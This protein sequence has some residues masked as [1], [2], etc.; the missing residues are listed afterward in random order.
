MS[1]KPKVCLVS[2]S[3]LCTNPRL[4]KEAHALSGAGYSVHVIAGRS[5]PPNDDFD[6]QITAR[7]TWSYTIVDYHG[8][9]RTVLQKVIHKVSRFIIKNWP[10]APLFIAAHAHHRAWGQ[11]M[12]AAAH[13]VP[14]IYIGHTLVGLAAAAEAA[15]K[16]GV[17]LGFDAEDF[18]SQET[19][20][21]SQD[22]AEKN[23]IYRLESTYLPQCE[24]LTAASPLIAEAYANRYHVPTPSVVQNTFP[25]SESPPRQP[26]ARAPELPTKLYWFSQTIGSGRG[27]EEFIQALT[28]V[29]AR[30]CLSLRG[31]VL[32]QTYPDT[33]RN[34]ALS[35]GFT[36]QIEILPPA[37]AEEMVRL[38]AEH[39]IGLAL[40]NSFPLNRDICLT[41]KIYTYLLAGLPILCTPTSAQKRIAEELGSAAK[42]IDLKDA[43]STAEQIDDLIRNQAKFE[44]ARIT[45][46]KHGQD[47][48][49]W[50]FESKELIKIVRASLKMGNC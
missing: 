19:I 3:H 14:H 45:A 43:I 50:D 21:A 6:A 25:L 1:P 31:K 30:V 39:D 47:R 22:P 36:G 24:H 11:I 18:H 15:R 42:I 38:A 44:Q 27:L 41:N 10:G 37:P 20:N 9:W 17:K 32:D 23:A 2:G 7:A 40:E 8:K 16:N 12:K 29:R 13:H 33:L 4:V 49:N 46:W 34:L 26:P 28:Q 48:Y 35:S 5:Y